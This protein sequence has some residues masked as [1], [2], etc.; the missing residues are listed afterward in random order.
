VDLRSVVLAWSTA[1]QVAPF[2]IPLQPDGTFKI[3]AMPIG[4]YVAFMEKPAAGGKGP[5]TKYTIPGGLMI[6]EGTTDYTLDVGK[7]WRP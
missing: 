4:Q 6:K 2:G 7:G 3:G 1:K 5:P